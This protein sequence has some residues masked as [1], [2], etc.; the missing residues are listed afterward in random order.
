MPGAS[1]EPTAPAD[2]RTVVA[3]VTPRAPPSLRPTLNRVEARPEEDE[4]TVAK[5]GDWV[6]TNT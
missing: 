5:D 6:P 1:P 3:T 2:T 4:E